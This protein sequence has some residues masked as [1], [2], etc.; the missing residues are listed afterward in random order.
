MGWGGLCQA[1]REVSQ[2][3]QRV[4][5]IE[6][7]IRSVRPP[8]VDGDGEQERKKNGMKLMSLK[9]RKALGTG[10][11]RGRQ[12]SRTFLEGADGAVCFDCY[13]EVRR[14]PSAPTVRPRPANVDP[15]ARLSRRQPAS[16]VRGCGLWWGHQAR[17]LQSQA[18]LA[19]HP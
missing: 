3:C 17:F 7:K 15:P 12:E 10:P 16:M 14:G 13:G 5:R 19:I 4:T 9:L 8:L 18:F 6:M 1:G 11:Q 2:V